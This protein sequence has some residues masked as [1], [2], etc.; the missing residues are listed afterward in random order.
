GEAASADVAIE[1]RVRL[2]LAH[3]LEGKAEVL[4]ADVT[5]LEAL[6]DA[7]QARGL[8]PTGL[9][10]DVRYLAAGLAFS[11]DAQ[12]EALRAVLDAHPDPIVRKC[13]EHRFEVDDAA[14]ADQL[15]ADDR[16]NRPP[17]RLNHFVRPLGL[18]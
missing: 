5:A 10:D 13:A 11:R 16:H 4:A 7:R 12:R 18:F 15:L 6:D 8:A 3:R 14:R 2:V 1:E 9:T 17:R